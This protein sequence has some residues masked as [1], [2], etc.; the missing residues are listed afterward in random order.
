MH[1]RP[2][3]CNVGRGY[4]NDATRERTMQNK[5]HPRPPELWVVELVTLG[6]KPRNSRRMF[7]SLAAA[8]KYAAVISEV[9]AATVRRIDDIDSGRDLRETLRPGDTVGP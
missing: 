7:A 9:A 8:Q 2:V 6:D 3:M 1:P 5:T 4:V